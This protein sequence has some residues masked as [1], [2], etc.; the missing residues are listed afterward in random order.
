MGQSSLDF[1][2]DEDQP[3][4]EPGANAM[5][6]SVEGR[7]SSSTQSPNYQLAAASNPV[8]DA[9][10]AAAAT[11]ADASIAGDTPGNAPSNPSIQS[12]AA[13]DSEPAQPP[14]AQF[15]QG[16]KPPASPQSAV[17]Q[18]PAGMAPVDNSDALSQAGP[19]GAASIPRQRQSV[20]Q[21]GQIPIIDDTQLLQRYAAPAPETAAQAQQQHA[22][23]MQLA[24]QS[25]AQQQQIAQIN[26]GDPYISDEDGRWKKQTADPTT[27]AIHETDILDTGS[28][29]IDRGTGNIYVQTSEGPQVIGVDPQQKRLAQMVEQKGQAQAQESQIS[30]NIA[31]AKSALLDTQ[32]QLRS[33]QGIPER[34]SAQIGK[35]TQ[36]SMDPSSTA[37]SDQLQSARAALNKWKQQNPR[38]TA[39][40]AKQ[41]ALANQIQ[42]QVAAKAQ[43]DLQVAQLLTTPQYAQWNGNMPPSPGAAAQDALAPDG[44]AAASDITTRD[45]DA[46]AGVIA[47]HTG[48]PAGLAYVSA[49]GEAQKKGAQTLDGSPIEDA[50]K[51]IHPVAQAQLL[52][53]SPPQ[54]RQA[55]Q[56]GLI[57]QEQARS[58][59]MGNPDRSGQD[60][61]AATPDDGCQ[62]PDTVA[63]S[64]ADLT[65]KASDLR[66]RIQSAFD[67]GGSDGVKELATYRA[68]LADT[69]S[70]LHAATQTLVNRVP[71]VM[72][73]RIV[74]AVAP[75]LDWDA[76][77]LLNAQDPMAHF[78]T[79]NLGSALRDH[80]IASDLQRRIR[81]LARSRGVNPDLAD[82]V[83]NQAVGANAVSDFMAV[84]RG[85]DIDQGRAETLQ[86]MGFLH[87]SDP[88]DPIS[89]LHLTEDA[90]RLLTPGGQ[91]FVQLKPDMARYNPSPDPAH[92]SVLYQNAIA[93]MDRFSNTARRMLPARVS[94]SQANSE[95]GSAGAPTQPDLSRPQTPYAAAGTPKIFPGAGDQSVAHTGSSGQVDRLATDIETIA[96][97]EALAD[98]LKQTAHHGVIHKPLS[99]K[100]AANRFVAGS[101][102]PNGLRDDPV[103]LHHSFP[104]YL[105]GHFQQIL[106]PLPKSLHDAYHRGLDEFLPRKSTTAFYNNMTPDARRQM[107]RELGA[108]T[109]VFDA[110]NGTNL[111]DAMVREGFPD[112]P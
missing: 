20:K 77:T 33:F 14:P 37:A 15:D 34:M 85:R 60:Q 58:A 84:L 19:P 22:A 70:H 12:D 59:A 50:I 56:S 106:E 101:I 40:S 1:N 97:T 110:K 54:L 32:R 112:V 93:G 28:G 82:H 47:A 18:Q 73:Q 25:Q 71:A 64:V 27:G 29:K 39:L 80:A 89:P 105:G 11:R 78:A 35:Y 94:V 53:M 68:A 16:V 44:S 8:G 83:A 31:A 6:N 62:T 86:D 95:P 109:K 3:G 76:T 99:M 55:F 24:Q 21:I 104:M 100:R 96:D 98:G 13:R 74:K 69:E 10:G 17:T 46:R 65:A 90:Q 43:N 63:L 92:G 45:L 57:T 51:G 72:Q 81:Q 79:E 26:Q 52:K 23:W 42:T 87:Q 4:E 49:L 107:L 9:A 75:N 48:F 67:T 111:F 30:A 36:A 61:P 7:E 108:Y 41:D 38:Y 5:P 2:A 91:R 88:S 66:T 102:F 103:H